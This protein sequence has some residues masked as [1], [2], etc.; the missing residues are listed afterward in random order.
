MFSTVSV[1]SSTQNASPSSPTQTDCN[2]ILLMLNTGKVHTRTI[3]QG[4]ILS[5]IQNIQQNV[6][7][8]TGRLVCHSVAREVANS[9]SSW[10]WQKVSGY[11]LRGSIDINFLNLASSTYSTTPWFTIDSQTQQVVS[12]LH[13]HSVVS[14]SQG[15]YS[16]LLNLKTP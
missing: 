4:S 13:H 8:K 2:D 7:S 15:N 16:D 11:L 3:P 6:V 1:G 5:K 12:W 9:F 10:G 14:D